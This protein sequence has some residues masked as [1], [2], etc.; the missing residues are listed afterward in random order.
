MLLLLSLFLL[1]T[2]MGCVSSA[3]QSGEPDDAY[4]VV[5][6]GGSSAAV[7]AAVAVKRLGKTALIVSPDQHLGGLSS[8]GL[9]ATDV[10]NKIAVTGMARQFYRELGKHYDVPETWAFE[11]HHAEEL[12]EAMITGAD[13]PV[14]RDHHLVDVTKEGSR[15]TA[16]TVVNASD[17]DAERQVIGAQ[18]IDATY[19]G[20]LL[21][22]AG[23]SYTVGRES[24]DTYGETINGVQVMG[25]HQF[26]AAGSGANYTIDPYVIQGDASSGL[27][28][29]ISAEPLAPEG[30]GD[31]LVQAYNYRLCLTQR[32]DNRVPFTKPP[33]YDARHYA[34]LG[35]L[36]AERT[37]QGWQHDLGESY[38]SLVPMP[39]GKTDVNNKGPFSTDFIGMN[40]AYPEAGREERR[41]MD[42][43]HER[44]IRGLLYYLANDPAVAPELREQTQSWGWAAD[45]F[46]DNDYFPYKLYIRE[47]RRMIGDYVMTE[48]HCLGHEV[49]ND[50]IGLAAYTMDSHNCQRIVQRKDGKVF[51]RNEGNVE[52]GGFPPFPIAYRSLTPKRGECTNLLVPVCLSSSHIAYGSIRMEPVFMVLGQAAAL[53]AVTAID[54]GIAVQDVRAG[55]LAQRLAQDPRFDGSAPDLLVDNSDSVHFRADAA[56]RPH[57]RW[58]GTYHVDARIAED[59]EAGQ[60][61]HFALPVVTTGKYGVY[62]YIPQP[63]KG[64]TGYVETVSATLQTGREEHALSIPLGQRSKE[65]VKLG[66]FELL[67]TDPV[68]LTVTTGGDQ[69]GL[70]VADA[71]LLLPE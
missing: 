22:A 12:Y 6:Y 8:S 11:P 66:S 36:I 69:D 14:W 5:I 47:G 17:Y 4:D 33:G 58:M 30:S 61:A 57:L 71:V 64:D 19:V 1:T 60:Q 63:P 24:N 31:S 39:A 10:G 38:L 27:L 28:Y 54:E 55:Q 45:E 42:E 44:Y 16:V 18:F 32:E 48:H 23:V 3:T 70:V 65:W 50:P 37:A 67:A 46:V 41:R 43:E 29:G 34:L 9:G 2:G 26:P 52:V 35:R 62:Y 7:I 68:T 51:V 49:V 59:R 25:G 20:D 53:A 21:A 40:Y 13:V 15:I 56:F